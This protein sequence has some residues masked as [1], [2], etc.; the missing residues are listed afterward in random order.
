MKVDWTDTAVGHLDHIFAYVGATSEDY[1]RRTIDRITKR[2]IQIS[3]LPQSGRIVPE[4]DLPQIREVIEGHYR[5]VY[6]IKPDGIDVLAVIHCAQD[7]PWHA[8]AEPERE[9]GSGPNG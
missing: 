1:A 2:S 9:P 8:I 7:T 5:I 3:T 4:L 6:Y